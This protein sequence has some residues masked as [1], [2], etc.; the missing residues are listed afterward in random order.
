MKLKLDSIQPD[1]P[2]GRFQ[3]LKSRL[4]HVEHL[5]RQDNNV[6]TEE[7][8]ALARAILTQGS[9][10]QEYT[11][12]VGVGDVDPQEVEPSERKGL[13]TGIW[14]KVKDWFSRP[15]EAEARKASKAFFNLPT[16]SDQAFLCSLPELVER[17]ATFAEVVA[18][19]QV[20]AQGHL[21]SM[22]G[23][24]FSGPFVSQLQHHMNL[25]E[26]SSL[27]DSLQRSLAAEERRS[28]E[29]LKAQ[30]IEEIDTKETR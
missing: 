14:L 30:L 28:W 27:E 2:K 1:G 10:R 22:L 8:Q 15:D 12:L 16:L 18:E 21:S 23:S 17:Q 5:L 9:F 29:A 19:I 4:R 7:V 6:T 13:R 25:R 26:K 20:L 3:S 24:L 11:T